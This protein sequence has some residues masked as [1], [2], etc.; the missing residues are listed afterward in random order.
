M[1]GQ[2]SSA[3]QAPSVAIVGGG[4]AGLAAACALADNGFTVTLFER[5]P[6]LGGRASSYEHPGTGEIVDN[7]QHVLFGVCTNLMEFYE[8]LG[9]AEKIRWFDEMNFIEPGGR[10]SVLR[11]TALPAPFQTLPSFASF[12]FLSS[13]DKL[14]IARAM[15]SLVPLPAKDTGESFL[16]WLRRHGQTPAAIDRFWNPILISA[17]SDDLD[18]ISVSAA[19]QVIRE[20]TRS[21]AARRMGI[22]AVPLTELYHAA[23][24]YVTQRGGSVQL[25]C[26][27]TT[28]EPS[29]DGVSSILQTDRNRST[30]PF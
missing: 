17:L 14:A 23:E 1:N 5:R 22:P 20:T 19:G 11:S 26:G 9:A 3:K 18:R 21:N 2:A 6:F 30:L 10:I 8:R 25:R 16:T 28:I 12:P 13:R 27:V 29:P 15:M 7:C 24:G 4:L